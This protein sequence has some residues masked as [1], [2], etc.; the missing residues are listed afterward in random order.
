MKLYT[1]TVC[2]KCMFIKNEIERLK[3]DV[4][5][6]NMDKVPEARELVLSKGIMAAPVLELKGEFYADNK[7][8]L[9]VLMDQ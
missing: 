3:L 9:A 5:L 1:K 7:Q 4:E 6:I 2:P 8:I